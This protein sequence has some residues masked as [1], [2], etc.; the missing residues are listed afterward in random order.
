MKRKSWL[1]GLALAVLLFAVPAYAYGP[2]HP[3]DCY[4]ETG[5]PLTVHV[6]GKYVSTDVQPFIKNNRTYLPVRVATE[7]MGATVTWNGA[8]RTATIKK[9]NTVIQCTINNHTFTVNGQAHYSDV[10]PLLKN[11][12]TML[13]IRQIAEA[14][15][16]KVTWDG[17]TASVDITTGA[18]V[19][20][21]PQLPNDVPKEVRWLLEKYYVADEGQG[22]GT[23]QLT[24][25]PKSGHYTTCYLC[26]SQ[27]PN[28][29]QRNAIAI[30]TYIQPGTNELGGIGIIDCPLTPTKNGFQLKNSGNAFYW[31]GL[32]IGSS[33]AY[34]KEN[35]TYNG[36]N[37]IFQSEHIYPY[38]ESH[39]VGGYHP[40]GE[41]FSKI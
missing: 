11:N 23:W 1:L 9:G 15:G 16:G 4:G 13:P 22:V 41:H 35:Y 29:T 40:I 32:G 7:S 14:L 30:H 21:K 17:N 12:R 27:M 18:P 33:M 3:H 28:S 25:E 34:R 36:D 39:P 31:Y 8:T 24:G 5:I 20:A 2:L 19:Q 38:F 37:L 26:I 6:D 10:A